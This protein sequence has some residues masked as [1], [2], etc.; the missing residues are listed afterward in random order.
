[1]FHLVSPMLPLQV[2]EKNR[3]LR[4]GNSFQGVAKQVRCSYSSSMALATDKSISGEEANSVHIGAYPIRRHPEQL[5]MLQG[6]QETHH[7]GLT[8]KGDI[9]KIHSLL[10]QGRS[11]MLDRTSLRV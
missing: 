11:W 3:G 9:Q 5:Q 1:M 10:K 8:W 4:G 2:T 6:I 7:M